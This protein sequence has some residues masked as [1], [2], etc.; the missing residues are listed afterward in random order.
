[1]SDEIDRANDSAQFTNDLAIRQHLIDHALPPQL[2]V[3]G[4]VECID[5][6]DDISKER[7]GALPNCVRCIDCQT[8]FEIREKQ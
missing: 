5:C 7:L 8:I 1:M 6:G 2:V 3:D 4:V